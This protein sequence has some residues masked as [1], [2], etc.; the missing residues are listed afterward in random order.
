MDDSFL[1]IY[2]DGVILTISVGCVFE[3]LQQIAMRFNRNV[4]LDEMKAM[5]NAKILRRCGRRISK[6]FYEFPVSTNSVKFTEIEVVNDE[7]VEI[8]VVLYCGNGSDKNA[9]IHLFAELAGMEQNEDINAFDEEYEVEEP[10]MVAPISYVD[11]ESTMGGIGIDLNITPDIDV[12]GGEEESGSDHSDEEVDSDSDP[13][14]DDVPNDIDD[15]DVNND[16]N[17]NASSVG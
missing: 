16:G 1:C 13:D 17:I 5:I 7:D 15:E 6:I 12:V 3:C 9:L 11:S 8:M 2:F 4:S 14:V 10:W